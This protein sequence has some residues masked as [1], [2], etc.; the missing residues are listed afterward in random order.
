[1]GQ[2]IGFG[3]DGKCYGLLFP[4]RNPMKPSWE[5]SFYQTERGRKIGI[6]YLQGLLGSQCPIYKYELTM[7]DI[8]SRSVIAPFIPK[9][10]SSSL[11]RVV[12]VDWNPKENMRPKYKD[13]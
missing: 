3:E 7:K 9:D 5:M 1:M 11:K 10:R 13:N 12:K 2:S 8:V 6:T 4:M